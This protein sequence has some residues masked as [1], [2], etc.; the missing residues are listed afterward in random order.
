MHLVR[1]NWRSDS[2][3]CRSF[4]VCSHRY[5]IWW[6]EFFRSMVEFLLPAG[7]YNAHLA[8]HHSSRLTVIIQPLCEYVTNTTPSCKEVMF[9][10]KSWVLMIHTDVIL[11]PRFKKT[12]IPRRFFQTSSNNKSGVIWKRFRQNWGVGERKR[13]KEGGAGE[14]RY[15]TLRANLVNKKADFL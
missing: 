6:L 13:K 2:L 15:K 8:K 7:W 4:L 10:T 14:Y 1:Y 5:A 11:Y 3:N 12:Y 9:E